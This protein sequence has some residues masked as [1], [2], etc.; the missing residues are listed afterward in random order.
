[1][2]GIMLLL[3]KTGESSE[4]LSQHHDQI[5]QL[6]RQVFDRYYSVNSHKVSSNSL[7]F[8][9]NRN[10]NE[11]IYKDSE[12]NWLG[13][14]G[15]VFALRDTKKLTAQEIWALYCEYGEDFPNHLDGH[16]VIKIYDPEKKTHLI[17]ND[18]IKDKTN[19]VCETDDYIIITPFLVTCALVTKPELDL[20]ALNEFMWRYYILS[21]RSLFQNIRRLQPA[22]IQKIV[23]GELSVTNYWEWPHSY[24][25]M[26]FENAVDEMVASM[27][28]T[29]QLLYQSYGK[30]CA[31][32]T[33]GQDS[34][35]II[36]AFTS[37]GLP[38]VTATFGQN[39]F[40]EV[41]A[42]SEMAQ[43][44][45][46]EHHQTTLLPEFLNN[47]GEQ[48]YRTVLLGSCEEPGYLLSRILHMKEQ[49]TQFASAAINGMDGHFYKN[50]LWDEQYTFNFYH[51]PKQFNIGTFLKYRALS[52]N[53]KDA[54]FTPEFREIKNDSTDY[55]YELVEQSIASHLESPVSIQVDKFDL[56]HWLNFGIAANNAT[57][58]LFPSLSPLL[59]RRNL[60]LALRI[61]VQ[62]KFNLS[63]FQRAVVY[64]LSPELAKEPTDFAGINMVPKN[65]LTIIPFYS[66]YFYHQSG[67][68]RNKVKSKLGFNVVTHLQEAWNY[69]PVFK[70]MYE[71]E[72]AQNHLEYK[73]LN[74]NHIIQQQEWETLIEKFDQD[75]M[76][77]LSDYEYVLKLLSVELLCDIAHN[78]FKHS[79]LTKYD[80]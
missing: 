68:F 62:W 1:M 54:I 50:G 51:E 77:Q 52:N 74:I 61:P 9:F 48:F 33:M 42:V 71:S 16:F 75:S 69:F 13:F 38:I 32:F 64:N 23:Q 44:H 10:D 76:T 6:L 49:Y 8:T 31:D 55:F 15:E 45:D 22:S 66:R 12:G 19:F 7:A 37:Q 14:E 72:V 80:Y 39:E 63:K 79:P 20:Y 57:N 67:R 65:A 59:L 21:F 36:S 46:I 60:E 43:R 78:I 4:H 28:E 30:V 27:Q 56:Q 53:Y 18:F 29:A 3:A 35:Q 73:H 26:S 25:E 2:N 40:Y 17:I 34:R 24:T 5:M 70:D 41:Q 11:S 58:A 47:P